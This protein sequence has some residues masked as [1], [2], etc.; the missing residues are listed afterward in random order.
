V[1]L[2][3][4]KCPYF[5][6]LFNVGSNFKQSLR[7][8]KLRLNTRYFRTRL[9]IWVSF[10]AAVCFAVFTYTFIKS[11]IE[12]LTTA[13]NQTAV[14]VITALLIVLTSIFVIIGLAAI[15]TYREQLLKFDKTRLKRK[16]IL[17]KLAVLGDWLT[18]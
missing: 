2:K 10:T 6:K 18:N 3:F 15:N 7:I 17:P 11:E 1:K 13:S 4:S 9:A 5:L 8:I 16:G 12:K 14:I